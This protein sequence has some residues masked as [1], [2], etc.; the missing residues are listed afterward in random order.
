[1]R[2]GRGSYAADRLDQAFKWDFV[3]T[4]PEQGGT[5]RGDDIRA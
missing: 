3:A 1:M 2:R 5:I 4:L